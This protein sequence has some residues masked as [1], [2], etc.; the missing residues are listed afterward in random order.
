M[1]DNVPHVKAYWIMISPDVM[2]AGLWYGADDVDG[3]VLREEIVHEAGATTPQE[4]QVRELTSRIREA[5]RLPVERDALYR[6][7]APGDDEAGAASAAGGA[8]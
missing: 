1:L 2:Q 3:S 7:I 4:L 8:R 5:G 6:E